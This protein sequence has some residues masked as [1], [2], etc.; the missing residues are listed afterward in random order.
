MSVLSFHSFQIILNSSSKAIG[1]T[2]S[3]P[4][5]M[6]LKSGQ[7][8]VW[9][10]MK[11][12]GSKG[13]SLRINLWPDRLFDHTAEVWVYVSTDWS[14]WCWIRANCWKT[15]V[16]WINF[17]LICMCI[18]C[19]ILK[20]KNNINK[21]LGWLLFAL[22]L[23]NTVLH[24]TLKCVAPHINGL[25][26]CLWKFSFNLSPSLTPPPPLTPFLSSPCL[27]AESLKLIRLGIWLV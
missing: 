6:N 12:K 13:A 19:V 14:F 7:P 4:W 8:C 11:R 25:L 26:L 15:G 21:Y 20:I 18:Q 3:R 22:V 23:T 1:F 17:R 24:L 5:A 9:R 2:G 16:W 10:A 27:L